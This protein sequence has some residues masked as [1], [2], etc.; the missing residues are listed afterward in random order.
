MS[1]EF[2]ISVTLPGTPEH[3]TREFRE[4]VVIG[5]AP[6]CG[7]Q[8]VHPLVSRRHAEVS[9]T[10]EGRFNV[11]DLGSSNGTIVNDQM[12]ANQETLLAPPVVAQVGP[13]LLQLTPADLL[14]EATLRRP[15]SRQTN[16][17][18]L[19]SGLHVLMVDGQPAIEGL[20]GLE[21]KLAEQ[22]TA[23]GGKLVPIRELGDALWGAG[24]WDPYMLHNLVRRVRRKLE[25]KG[26]AAESLIVSVPGGGYHIV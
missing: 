5:R 16:R 9:F 13:Y 11:R 6:E 25:E 10:D 8:L 23:A 21:Y 12:L 26:L 4:P 22:L 15:P 7:L 14:A 18:S 2:V 3:F 1:E 20:T 19:D 24:A 17:V